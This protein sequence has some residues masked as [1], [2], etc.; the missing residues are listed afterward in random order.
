MGY[1][2]SKA[3]AAGQITG[4]EYKTLLNARDTLASKMDTSIKPMLTD[5]SKYIKNFISPSNGIMGTT[6][7]DAENKYLK[8]NQALYREAQG[9][10]PE[11]VAKLVDFNDPGS[12]INKL[13]DANTSDK[14]NFRGAMSVPKTNWVPTI[15]EKG[16]PV[17]SPD[18]VRQPGETFSEWKKRTQGK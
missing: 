4:T 2:C 3:V 9:K 8:V 14:P 6:N 13:I 10:T 5:A 16:T 11:Q 1:S 18:K 17:I 7:P 12:F 15:P